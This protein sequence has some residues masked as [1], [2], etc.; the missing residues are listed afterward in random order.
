MRLGGSSG[1]LTTDRV[2]W[3]EMNWSLAVDEE[4]GR[5]E[6]VPAEVLLDGRA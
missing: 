4:S 1:L 3:E 6:A 5:I 2:S